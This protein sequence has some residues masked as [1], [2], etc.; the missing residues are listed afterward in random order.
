[1]CQE[2]DAHLPQQNGSAL[3]GESVLSAQYENSAMQVAQIKKATAILAWIFAGSAC[4]AIGLD[5][6]HTVTQIDL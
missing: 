3:A 4:N 2:K 1:M 6:V 5:D